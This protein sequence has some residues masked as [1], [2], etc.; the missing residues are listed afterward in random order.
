MPNK[1]VE[2]WVVSPSRLM[3]EL[4][5]MLLAQRCGLRVQGVGRIEDIDPSVAM[6][7]LVWDQPASA[8]EANHRRISRLRSQAPHWKIITLDSG[9]ASLEEVVS[10][11]RGVIDYPGPVRDRLTSLEC[12]VLL[13][14]VAGLRNTDIARRMRRSYKTVEKHRANLQRKLGLKSLALLTA[15]AIQTGLILPEAILADKRLPARPAAR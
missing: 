8:D 9:E 10:L 6:R 12:E 2:A 13:G 5:A 14:L 3:R 15:Y 7:V 1:S 11:V 4:L